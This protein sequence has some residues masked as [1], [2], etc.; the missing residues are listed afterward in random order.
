MLPWYLKFIAGWLF[1]HIFDPPRY[2]IVILHIALAMVTMVMAFIPLSNAPAIIAIYFIHSAISIFHD[3]LFDT[4]VAKLYK[5]R[6]A[7]PALI[8]FMEYL[9]FEVLVGLLGVGYLGKQTFIYIGVFLLASIPLFWMIPWHSI[10][11]E[12]PK[13]IGETSKNNLWSIFLILIV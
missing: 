7:L 10:P 4:H 11:K 6:P 5:D 8:Q 3:A 2:L 9:T 13:N 12:K 1:S